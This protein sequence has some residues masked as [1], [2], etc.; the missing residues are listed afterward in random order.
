MAFD[1]GLAERLE[2]IVAMRFAH[3]DGL[4]ET[5][6]FGGFGY[7]LNG[8]MCIGIHKDT[9]IIRVGV[10]T[11]AEIIGEPGVRPMDLT[12]KVM[13][14]WATLEPEAIAEDSD[15]ERF[16]SLAIEF[17]TTLPVKVKA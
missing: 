6:M 2:D 5:R 12:G 16:C 4:S 11:A 3:M 8:N 13:K 7:M 17:V 14:G 1:P 9:L 10:D 15:I